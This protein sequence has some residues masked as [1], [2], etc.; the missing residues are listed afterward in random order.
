MLVTD[1]NYQPNLIFEDQAGAINAI[2]F[3]HHI[4]KLK[5]LSPYKQYHPSQIF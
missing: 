1:F 5:H 2:K 3:F 4:T